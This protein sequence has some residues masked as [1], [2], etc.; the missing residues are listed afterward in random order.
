MSDGQYM[1][2]NNNGSSGSRS[3][4]N[5]GG[6]N[7]AQRRTAG[8]PART[9]S[10]TGRT[11]NGGSSVPARR[12]TAQPA[13]SQ[14]S[15]RNRAVVKRSGS[16]PA[17]KTTAKRVRD[18]RPDGNSGGGGGL[19][20]RTGN[21]AVTSLLKAVIYIMSI[22]VISGFLSYFAI[23]A[24]ND[25]F[26]FV[27]EDIEVSVTIE[28]GTDIKTLGTKLAE[29]GV[30]KYPKVFSLYA[31][32]RKKDNVTLQ[33]GEYTVSPMMNYDS[34]IAAFAKSNAVERTTVVVTIPEG[35]TVDQIIDTLV[36]KYGLS[37]E[38][39]LKDAIENYD[40]DYWFVKRLETDKPR[41]GRKYRL[42]GYL[43][44]DTYYYFSDSSAAAIIYKML[45]NF[46]KKVKDIFR[47]DK[48]VPGNNY[49]EKIDYLCGNFGLSFDDIVI[50]ASMV[51]MEGKYTPE[52]GA[53]SS[54]FHNR[55]K[56][57]SV[58]NGKLE[59]DATLQYLL[60]KR[61][62]HLTE[63]HKKIDSPYNTYLYDGLP[64]G[65]ISN[66]AQTAL[67][68]AL[69]PDDTKYYFFVAGKDGY[70]LFAK[71]YKEHQQNIAKVNAEE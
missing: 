37:S 63:E 52:Y 2:R 38:S 10:G 31:K 67:I 5:Y 9:S 6:Y 19:D 68:Y 18:I 46:D 7:G 24:G 47:G 42:E 58:T 56:N 29:E 41:Y 65:A 57:P 54:V 39:E 60:D 35:Y 23:T 71:T 32:L 30:I 66:P 55:L 17:K 40:Y 27:K 25:V 21:T 12:T 3:G 44:P 45:D 61:T 4:G 8:S 1:N 33:A 34:L 13:R 28:E 16:Y 26:A 69:Y 59:S 11:Q 36:N 50:I 64:P 53:I 48:T 14:Q 20:D 70:S 49:I 51:Q 22:L 15:D 62:E 43:Y